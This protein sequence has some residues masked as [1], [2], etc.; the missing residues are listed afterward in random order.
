MRMQFLGNS[1]VTFLH[2]FELLCE[3]L[4]E[5]KFILM[6][7]TERDECDKKNNYL[8]LTDLTSSPKGARFCLPEIK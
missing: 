7:E 2:C 3:V 1:N 8:P 6:Y 5:V 4:V